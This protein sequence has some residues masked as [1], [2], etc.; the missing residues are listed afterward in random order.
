MVNVIQAAKKFRHATAMEFAKSLKAVAAQIV[1]ASNQAVGAMQY[2][3]PLSGYAPVSQ[4]RLSAKMAA[5]RLNAPA[6]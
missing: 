3:I 5:A 4:A 1:I 2:A 6:K